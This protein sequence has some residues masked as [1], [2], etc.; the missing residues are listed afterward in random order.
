MALRYLFLD[1]NAFFA[2]CEALLRPELRGRAIGVVPVMADTSCCIAASYEAKATGVRTGTLVR[3]ARRLCPAI[4]LVEAR[5]AE[6]IQIHRQLLAALE[7]AIHVDQV[8]SI[9]EVSAT[10]PANW[11][12][13]DLARAAAMRAKQAVAAGV[14]P[15]MRCSI[16]IAPNLYLAKTASDM[17]KPD[18]LVL[19]DQPDLPGALYRLA[20]DDLCGVGARMGLRLAQAGITT[21]QDLCEASSQRLR[22]IWGGIEGERM[23][24]RLRGLDFPAAPTYKRQIGHSHVLAPAL[25]TD[26]LARAVAHRLLEKAAMRLRD[27]GYYAGELQ[28]QMAF[29]R[30]YPWG[31]SL[32][33]DPT[34]D[35]V[36]FASALNLLLDRREPPPFDAEPVSVGV[37]LGRL[38]HSSNH[39]QSL[40]P[41]AAERRVPLMRIID[42]VNLVY[43]FGSVYWGNSHKGRSA[44]PMRIPFGRVPSPEKEGG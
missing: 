24:A 12:A 22:A 15:T 20:L 28:A 40:F 31:N 19:L 25:R 39:T 29:R 13:P 3:D 23:W 10:L 16:G 21:V 1:F 44:A 27:Q 26:P 43:G 34:Q 32:R 9:D 6:Y 36:E 41:T 30:G 35:T 37:V 14:G 38:T 2:N 33:I 18:G 11:Q 7:K 17:Q 5:P 42:G 4:T 8:H